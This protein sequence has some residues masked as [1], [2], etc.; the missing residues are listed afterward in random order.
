MG[1][2]QLRHS[3]ERLVLKNLANYE[4]IFGQKYATLVVEVCIFPPSVC[5]PDGKA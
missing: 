1:K 3:E 4:L 2:F 5:I